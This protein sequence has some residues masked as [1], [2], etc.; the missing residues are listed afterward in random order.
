MKEINEVKWN[1]NEKEEVEVMIFTV[2][3]TEV[4]MSKED[5]NDHIQHG[6]NNPVLIGDKLYM[7]TDVE[8]N[9]LKAIEQKMTELGLE[10]LPKEIT[11]KKKNKQKNKTKKK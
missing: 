10:E 6:H 4:V 5:Y 9:T 7:V 11:K 8:L 2:N 1:D 3:G